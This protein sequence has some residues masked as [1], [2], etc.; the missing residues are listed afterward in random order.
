MCF[1]RIAL[2]WGRLGVPFR[3]T[4]VTGD[5][6]RSSR[7]GNGETTQCE[8]YGGES[9]NQVAL[10]MAKEEFVS[11]GEVGMVM[12]ISHGMQCYMLQVLW[13][14]KKGFELEKIL[15]VT[16]VK[17]RYPGKVLNADVS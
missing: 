4:G 2:S 11:P 15:D 17:I 3:T 1:G 10:D 13:T 7:S 9:S 5:E 14:I 6:H 16:D 12:N 8:H